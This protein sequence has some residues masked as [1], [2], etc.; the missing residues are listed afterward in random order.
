MTLHFSRQDGSIIDL[1]FPDTE[2]SES[3]PTSKD[4]LKVE[5]AILRFLVQNINR[6]QR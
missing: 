4:S 6:H 2:A 1:N 5:E 3:E